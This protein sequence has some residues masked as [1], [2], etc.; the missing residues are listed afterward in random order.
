MVPFWGRRTTHFSRYVHWGYG[1]LTHAHVSL[2]E[3]PAF[4]ATGSNPRLP[5][6]DCG[7]HVETTIL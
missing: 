6:L 3:T 2:N 7:L 1:I 4:A 5:G